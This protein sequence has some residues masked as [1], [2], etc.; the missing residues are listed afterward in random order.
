MFFHESNLVQEDFLLWSLIFFRLSSKLDE[1]L[2]DLEMLLLSFIKEKLLLIDPRDP[3]LDMTFDVKGLMPEPAWAPCSLKSFL[4]FDD[5]SLTS[6][7]A[8]AI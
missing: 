1:T 7:M 3:T 2:D 8:C 6:L 4:R 5:F